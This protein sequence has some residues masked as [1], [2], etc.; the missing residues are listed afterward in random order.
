MQRPAMRDGSSSL[1]RGLA[2]LDVFEASDGELTIGELSRRSG[3]PKSTAHRLAA[4]L[5][6][7]GALERGIDGLRLGVRLFE[8]GHLVPAQRRLRELALPY[9]HHLNEVTK[10]TCNLAV[11]EGY[12][13]VYVE[14]ITSRGLKVPHTRA[15]GRLPLTV[16][17]LGKAIL[18]FSDH[19]F[20]ES[21]L[22][23]PLD[24]PTA[25]SIIDPATLRTE[26]ARI[27]VDKVAYDVEESQLGLFCVA[28]PI[29]DR[30]GS[31]AG[32]ISVT[33]ATALSQAERFAPVVHTTAMAL[34]RALAGN[35][36]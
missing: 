11:R 30:D 6:E 32:A 5:I 1:S 7:W 33:G 4:D 22:A 14:K 23:A 20:V 16:T 27:R 35:R 8:L 18:A 10:L 17:G 26:L 12:E 21:V 34:S 31:V 15:G 25:R 3:I 24:A 19:D 28:S 13:I 36:P 2:L 9:A 29:F